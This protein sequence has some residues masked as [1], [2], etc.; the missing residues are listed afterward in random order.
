[1]FFPFHCSY[2]D[3][4][5]ALETFSEFKFGTDNFTQSKF[6]VN[7]VVKPA[8]VFKQMFQYSVTYL[9]GQ[10]MTKNVQFR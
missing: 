2:L 9:P 5:S 6:G 7:M 10:C 8:H 1:M 4:I 3:D